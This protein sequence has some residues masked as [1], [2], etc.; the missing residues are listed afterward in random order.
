MTHSSQSRGGNGHAN[1]SGNGNGNGA[2]NR[3]A[4]FTARG[5]ASTATASSSIA[6]RR[7]SGPG[8]RFRAA[9][10]TGSRA[11]GGMRGA[12]GLGRRGGGGIGRQGGPSS[13][14]PHFISRAA[15]SSDLQP[16]AKRLLSP[17]RT[18]LY[19]DDDE[20]FA[21][22]P[23]VLK[24]EE[25]LSRELAVAAECRP[26]P[27]PLVTVKSEERAEILLTPSAL[28]GREQEQVSWRSAQ[29]LSIQDATALVAYYEPV[30][31]SAPEPEPE[32]EPVGTMRNPLLVGDGC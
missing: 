22:A 25:S 4:N 2:G 20:I 5:N 13:P 10:S 17:P 28:P 32:P 31:V 18:N 3:H 14:L 23:A 24:R 19:D 6:A 11:R 15:R 9:V 12:G 8:N 1:G 30:A 26:P 29:P 21:P 16:A 7:P 27:P